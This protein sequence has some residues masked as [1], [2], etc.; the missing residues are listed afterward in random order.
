VEL[1]MKRGKKKEWKN[2]WYRQSIKN[3]S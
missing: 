1:V 2:G 3:Y